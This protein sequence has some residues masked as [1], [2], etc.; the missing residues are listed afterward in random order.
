MIL[1][2]TLLPIFLKAPPLMTKRCASSPLKDTW[3]DDTD[4][5]QA[6]NNQCS[7]DKCNEEY[8]SSTGRELPPNDPVLTFEIPSPTYH[9]HHNGN[10]KEGR[11]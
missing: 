9:Q 4:H 6:C 7:R 1:V 2:P 10:A 3:I 11:P 8:T 5:N